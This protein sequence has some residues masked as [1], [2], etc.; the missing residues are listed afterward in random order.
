ME[1]EILNVI[2]KVS[3]LVFV[4]S[5]M[6]AMGLTTTPEQPE[7]TRSDSHAWAAHP[8]YGLLATVLGVRPAAPGFRRVRVAPHLGTLRHAEGTGPHPDGTIDV[9]V[10]ESVA[11][12]LGRYTV[13]AAA[14]GRVRGAQDD[15]VPP[16]QFTVFSFMEEK[17]EVTKNFVN[18][19]ITGCNVDPI[20]LCT[21]H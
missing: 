19:L 6:L 14:P 3:L 20:C 11:L 18:G 10:G 17:N 7:P 16:F 13:L 2:L 15:I 12:P 5:S 9:R 4:V 1:A 21:T 8:N